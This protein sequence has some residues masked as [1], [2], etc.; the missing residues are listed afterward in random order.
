MTRVISALK[1][2]ALL[3]AFFISTD[4]T[5]APLPYD[6]RVLLK[7]KKGKPVSVSIK[8]TFPDHFPIILFSLAFV[9]AIRNAYRSDL[10]G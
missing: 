10:I 6:E 5:K 9:L 2:G 4:D 8:C 7:N 3:K 1:K